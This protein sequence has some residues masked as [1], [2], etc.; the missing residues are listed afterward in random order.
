MSG[1]TIVEHN[2]GDTPEQRAT[3]MLRAAFAAVSG[4]QARDDI[5]QVSLMRI[6][7]DLAESVKWFTATGKAI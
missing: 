2:N 6:Q 5:E 3:D 7:L 4:V 1:G